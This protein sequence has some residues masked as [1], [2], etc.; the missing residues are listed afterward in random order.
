[1]RIQDG[2]VYNIT[3]VVPTDEYERWLMMQVVQTD[4]Q[5][6]LEKDGCDTCQTEPGPILEGR[7]PLRP[8]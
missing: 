6:D 4:Q 7:P 8:N 1:M 2:R 3:A 5:A